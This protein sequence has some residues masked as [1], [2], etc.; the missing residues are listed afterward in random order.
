MWF[1]DCDSGKSPGTR[2][3]IGKTDFA[4]EGPPNPLVAVVG[5]LHCSDNSHP[6]EFCRFAAEGIRGAGGT[7][8]EHCM[9]SANGP[10]CPTLCG[11]SRYEL[12]G[13]DLI[14]DAIE[15]ALRTLPVDAIVFI[16][17]TEQELAG[18]LLAALRLNIPSVFLP[19]GFN[20]LACLTEIMGL[21]LPG[22]A[23][24]A[25]D[26]TKARAAGEAGAAAVD[27]ARRRIRPRDI[28]IREVLE[29]AISLDIAL[30]GTGDSVLHL[31][32]AAREAGVRLELSD[33]RRIGFRVPQLHESLAMGP[34]VLEDAGGISA[35]ANVMEPLLFMDV[36][37]VTGRT[38]RDNVSGRQVRDSKVI[39]SLD[40]PL[41]GCGLHFLWGNLSPGGAVAKV[42]GRGSGLAE[43]VGPAV[44]VN[45]QEEACEA[46]RSCRLTAGSVLVVRYEGP[47]GGPGMRDLQ[48]LS[49]LLADS[50]LAESVFVISDGRIPS[51]RPG[52]FVGHITPE[53]YLGG[54]L[55]VVSDGD[56][57]RIHLEKRLLQVEVEGR[58]LGRRLAYWRPPA[59]RL[60]GALGHYAGLALPASEGAGMGLTGPGRRK[61]MHSIESA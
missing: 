14:A 10:S 44:V 30:G 4:P 53:A 26:P 50:G 25:A 38:L 57:I 48:E 42:S 37:T 19:I 41:G 51:M 35:M 9:I 59:R 7:P 23:T 29:N 15:I 2:A 56:F 24:C 3:D 33:F 52:L 39:R 60:E 34:A 1:W 61:S 46:V 45:S 21:A 5:V 31:L 22:C 40:T 18:Q 16:G 6:L 55:A 20:A 27:I 47:R 8:V 12:P 58:E 17:T 49:D 36:P 13:R 28:V 32:A 43:F 54:P 11:D